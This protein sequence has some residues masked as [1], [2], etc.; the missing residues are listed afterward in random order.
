VFAAAGVSAQSVTGSFSPTPVGA[1]SNSTLTL[2]YSGFTSTSAGMNL[3][4]YFNSTRVTPGS[5]TYGNPP[6]QSQPVTAATAGTLAG[7]T[8]ADQFITLN[9]VD[10]GG[11]WPTPTSGANLAQI[12]F[13]TAAGF[14]ASTAVCWE[15]DITNGAPE[16]NIT[17][18]AVLGFAAPTPTVS[19][20]RTSAASVLDDGTVLTFQVT[21]SNAPGSNITVNLTSGVTGAMSGVTNACGSSIQILSGNTTASCN[22]SATNTVPFDGPGTATVTVASGSGYNVA[23]GP[24]NT[25]NGTITNNDLPTVTISPAAA[26]VADNGASQ[27]VTVTLS[28]AAPTGGFVVPLTALAANARYSGTC[29][30]AA[31]LTVL[32]GQTTA[33][34]T[35]IGTANTTAGDGSVVANV[36]LNCTSTCTNGATATSAVTVIDDDVP[37]FN[38]TCVPTSVA[39]SGATS[40]CTFRNTLATTGSL[41]VNFTPSANARYTITG[42][43]SPLVV[44]ASAANTAVGTCTVTGVA[45]TVPGDGSVVAT[46]TPTAGTGYSPGTAGSVTVTDDDVVNVTV[47]PLG[48]TEGGNAQFSVACTGPAGASVT[49]LTYTIGTVAPDAP[50]AGSLPVG[51]LTCGTP[52]VFLVPTVNDTT[53]GN[54]RSVTF[55]LAGPGAVTGGGTPNLPANLVFT[56]AVADDDRPTVVPTMGAFGL[57]LLGLLVAGFGALVQRRRK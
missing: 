55:T 29:V 2:G 40:T 10:F 49:G 21:A 5:V 9:W 34:C 4:V 35:V 39:D 31:S 14:N 23:A 50:I 3:R 48:T 18:N 12:P 25:A 46:I 13:T 57:G 52:N 53:Q 27:T 8:D 41:N 24:N 56:A 7:C 30:G 38:V 16:R 19:I 45:N 47:T 22:I 42:C 26:N 54:A 32:A 51:T 11:T 37:V 6:G 1:S 44:P 15:D 17:G 36:A 20:A 33:S 28:A 43:V